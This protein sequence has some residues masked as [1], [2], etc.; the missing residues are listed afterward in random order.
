[1]RLLVLGGTRFLGRAIV[2]EACSRG[3]DVATFSRGLSGHPRPGVEPLRGDRANPGDLRQ[4]TQREW[5]AVIDTSVL[6]PAHVLASAQALADHARHYTYISTIS[7]YANHPAEGVT[8]SSPVLDCAADATGTVDSLGYGELKAGSERAVG[9][10]FPDRSLIVRP[11]LIVGP[12]ENVRWLTWWLERVARGG[13]VLAPGGPDKE[14][15][16]TDVRDLAAWVMDN[17]RRAL[18]ATINVPGAAGTTFGALLADCMRLASADGHAHAELRWAADRDLLAAGVSPWTELPMWAPDIPQFAG[19]WEMAGD[20]A[21][22]TGMRYR[23]LSDTVHDTWLW[24]KHEAAAGPAP[25]TGASLLSL[26][27]DPD[28]ERK[29]LAALD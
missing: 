11:G 1:M 3:Y 19:I 5:D 10:A 2:D 25:A 6:A 12:H 29:V 17:T 24:L 18:P 16:M 14:V 4:L 27:L 13:T 15:R 8:E 26:G 28:T 21:R 9:A 7:V 20:R 22:R 23:P